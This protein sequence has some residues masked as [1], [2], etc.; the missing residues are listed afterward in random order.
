MAKYISKYI[1]KQNSFY[2]HS[3]AKYAVEPIL[4]VWT[5]HG[6]MEMILEVHRFLCHT[7]R[8]Y[9]GTN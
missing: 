5:P 3:I 8:I 1:H 6:L 4:S 9:K 2:Q 7:F